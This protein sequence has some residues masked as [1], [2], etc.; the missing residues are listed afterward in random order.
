M[1]MSDTDQLR[2]EFEALKRSQGRSC[3]RD[4]DRLPDGEYI[5]FLMQRD[6]KYYQAGR[7]W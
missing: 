5:S 1:T 4:F 6:W 2:A 3:E 7:T